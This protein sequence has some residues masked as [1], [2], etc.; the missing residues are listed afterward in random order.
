[1]NRKSKTNKSKFFVLF[2]LGPVVAWVAEHILVKNSSNFSNSQIHIFVVISALLIV[3]W[4]II[5]IK[6]WKQ[7]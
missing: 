6:I 1:M 5:W 4:V 3:Y 2:W 7:A